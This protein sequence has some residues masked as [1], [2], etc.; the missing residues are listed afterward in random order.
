MAGVSKVV[1]AMRSAIDEFFPGKKLS[2]AVFGLE[3]GLCE[4]YSAVPRWVNDDV[5]IWFR[6]WYREH[7]GNLYDDTEHLKNNRELLK[8]YSPQNR[9][10]LFSF[11]FFNSLSLFCGL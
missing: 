11:I 2:A 7:P 10:R 6:R 3:R 9:L 1:W 4:P 8:N 5:P